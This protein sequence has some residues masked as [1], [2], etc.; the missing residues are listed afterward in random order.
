MALKKNLILILFLLF[1]FTQSRAEKNFLKD[2]EHFIF[3]AFGPSFLSGDL[4]GSAY[5]KI[6]LG[7]ND[8]SFNDAQY[9]LSA[10]IRSSL[11]DYW[12]YRLSLFHT[13]A[14]SADD[15]S[16][17]FYREYELKTEIQ[18]IGAHAEFSFLKYHIKSLENSVYL[19]AGVGVINSQTTNLSG[20]VR[21]KDTYKPNVTALYLPFG[22]G[23]YAQVNNRLFLNMELGFQYA[24]TDFLDGITTPDS[25]H[26]DMITYLTISASYSIF[27]KKCKCLNVWN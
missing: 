24:F 17:N 18:G 10:G 1:F 23:C 7:V 16:R 26:N 20:F 21:P 19:L 2:K 27:S 11:S 6:L 13:L 3:V 9:L 5:K 22:I 8:F 25:K 4:G 12:G 15:G 14:N